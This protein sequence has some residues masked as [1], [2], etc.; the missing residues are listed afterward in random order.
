M[1]TAGDCGLHTKY[2]GDQFCILPPPPDKGFQLHVGPTDYDNPE[3]QYILN[4]GDETTVDLPTVSTNDTDQYF[5]YR[6]IRQR[7]GAHHN[8]ITSGSGGDVGLGQRI[9]TS[10]DNSVDDPPMG[11]IAPENMDV[12]ILMPAHTSIDVNL[13]SINTSEATEVREVWV[14]FWYVDKGAVKEPVHEI[15]NIAPMGT[16]LPGDDVTFGSSCTVP[17][18]GRLLWAYGH[19]H[20]N[21]VRFSMW[22]QRGAQKDLI[23]QGYNYEEPLVLDYSSTVKNAVPDTGPNVEGGWSGIL[24]MQPGDVFSWECRVVNKQAVALNF[25]NNTFTGEMCIMDAESVGTTC[26]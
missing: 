24:D 19:R 1:M 15:F 25:T 8:I 17:G 4:P 12:G 2:A 22:R 14:N 21:N 26:P 20:A 16:I 13:H 5:Y 10:N 23:Y 18:M 7:T 9:A 11:I 6:Q 3:P